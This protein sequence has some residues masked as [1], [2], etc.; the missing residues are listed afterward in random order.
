MTI[1]WL[2]LGLVGFF[3]GWIWYTRKGQP[4]VPVVQ[5]E[6]T[7]PPP[8][9]V[10]RN[11]TPDVYYY[12]VPESPVA[13]EPSLPH[14]DDALDGSSQTMAGW[15]PGEFTQAATDALGPDSIEVLAHWAYDPSS[16]R[17]TNNATRGMSALW[18]AYQNLR[19][20]NADTF[21]VRQQIQWVFENT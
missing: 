3:F 18:T 9:E 15:A 4:V 17:P 2:W 20:V 5:V 7:P 13:D 16:D 8:V 12:P 21:R 1:K 19:A 11:P 6:P 10:P 14:V